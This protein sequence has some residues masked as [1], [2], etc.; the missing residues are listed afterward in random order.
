MSDSNEGSNIET[1]RPSLGSKLRVFPYVQTKF[2]SALDTETM[3][4]LLLV[5]DN[6]YNL[7]VLREMILMVHP[8]QIEE[9]MNGQEAL[10]KVLS[11]GPFDLIFMDLNMPVMDGI[12]CAKK[13]RELAGQGRVNLEQTKIIAV[14]AISEDIFKQKQGSHLFEEFKEKPLTKEV[15]QQIL[16][17]Q[18]E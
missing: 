13:L 3:P 6:S 9:A 14:S 16:W 8:L 2:I 10:D 4:K 11:E 15:I 18:R 12:E 17:M 1:V 7:F 5:D